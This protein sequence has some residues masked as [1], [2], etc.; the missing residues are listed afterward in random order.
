MQKELPKIDKD[1]GAFAPTRKDLLGRVRRAGSKT[2]V[3]ALGILGAHAAQIAPSSASTMLPVITNRRDKAETSPLVLE[4]AA[5]DNDQ[6]FALAH[7]SHS[8]HRSHY[9]SASGGGSVVTPPKTVTPPT[10]TVEATDTTSLV[11]TLTLTGTITEMQS[12]KDYFVI[13]DG[14][15]NIH[16]VYFK[17]ATSIRTLSPKEVT[18]TIETLKAFSGTFPLKVGKSVLVHYKTENAKKMAVLITT[19]EM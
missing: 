11:G 16:N 5:T 2:L 19:L 14:A 4:L 17:D 15:N 9:S 12:S 6:Q 10:K 13:K 3:A 18:T 8:S 7:R 1:V